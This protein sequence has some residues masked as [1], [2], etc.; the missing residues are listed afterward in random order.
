MLFSYIALTKLIVPS[1]DIWSSLSS[2]LHMTIPDSES[3]FEYERIGWKG[4]DLVS[5]KRR[6]S[7]RGNLSVLSK[8]LKFVS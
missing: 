1:F 5:R 2:V 4:M 8:E 3:F 6:G 7:V